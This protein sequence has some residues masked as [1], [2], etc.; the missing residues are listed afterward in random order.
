MILSGNIFDYAT[1]FAAG[2]AVSFTPCLYP[3]MPITSAVIAGANARGTR[4][5][6]FFLSCVYVLGLAVTY[7]ALGIAAVLTGQLFGSLQTNSMLFFL[8][9][10]VFIFFSLVMAD[11]LSLPFFHIGVQGAIKPK[12]FLGIF[13]IGAASG[14]VVGPCTAPVLGTLLLYVASKQNLVHA[15]SLLFIFSYGVGFSL[16]LVGTFS[17]F[18]A[19]LPKPGPWLM[20][21][22]KTC[23]FILFL[24][25]IYF[26]GKAVILLG[27]KL[28]P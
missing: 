1:V 12:N 15:I 7:S 19:R 6:G 22:K 26:L 16:I 28:Y 21:V 4:M 8:V 20:S 9:A 18:L 14:L 17:G 5:A 23:A 3:V 2:V 13:L 27:H 25:G 11:L 10:A 24:I